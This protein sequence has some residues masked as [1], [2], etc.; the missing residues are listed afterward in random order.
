MVSFMGGGGSS[1]N[2]EIARFDLGEH[3]AHAE[4]D[5]ACGSESGALGGSHDAGVLVG[6]EPDR[7]RF[8]GGVCFS[9]DTNDIHWYTMRKRFLAKRSGF[10]ML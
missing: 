7:D 10:G 3:L 1:W 2:F 9:H 5:D 4:A 6:F 8:C